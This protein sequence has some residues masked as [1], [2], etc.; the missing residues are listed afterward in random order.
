MQVR[1]IDNSEVLAKQTARLA[2]LRASRDPEAVSAALVAVE[3]A[4]RAEGTAGGEQKGANLLELAVQA[5]RVRC[6]LGEISMALEKVT[7]R[8]FTPGH[9][10][11]RSVFE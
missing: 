10:V 6:T 5:A 9:C 3:A 2:A 7:V 8:R 11:S 4:A 1:T